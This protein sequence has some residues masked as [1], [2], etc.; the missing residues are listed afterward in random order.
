MESFLDL[1]VLGLELLVLFGQ[2]D[3]L[4]LQLAIPVE[5]WAD[6]R[7]VVLLDFC[8]LLR[9]SVLLVIKL[10]LRALDEGL[11]LFSDQIDGGLDLGILFLLHLQLVL[12]SLQLLLEARLGFGGCGG[13]L[14]CCHG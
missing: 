6:F 5:E 14:G 1:N 4:L 7:L 11:V 9:Q 13:L 8:K 2:D 12:Q 3:E 10:V